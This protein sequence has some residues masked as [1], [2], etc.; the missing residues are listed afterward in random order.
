[1]VPQVG[2]H[3]EIPRQVIRPGFWRASIDGR[4]KRV[5]EIVPIKAAPAAGKGTGGLRRAIRQG[6]Y[7]GDF[8]AASV[9]KDQLNRT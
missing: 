3:L 5:A 8:E 4:Q 1:M 9:L 2:A 7:V 6:A